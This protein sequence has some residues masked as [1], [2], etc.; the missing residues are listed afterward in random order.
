MRKII[1]AVI[2]I[3]FAL[4][5][6]GCKESKNGSAGQA[7]APDPAAAQAQAQDQVKAPDPG[8][9]QDDQGGSLPEAVKQT[10]AQAAPSGLQAVARQE[11]E[12]LAG[13]EAIYQRVNSL[14]KQFGQGSLDRVKLNHEL[15]AVK[16]QMDELNQKAGDFYKNLKLT[17]EEK[18]NPL[19]AD[20][21]RNGGRLRGVVSD[22]ISITVEGKQ[23]VNLQQKDAAGN[24]LIENVIYN[25]SKIKDYFLAQDKKYLEYQSKLAKALEK[26]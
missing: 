7:A 20:G 3:V 16:P 24:Y 26:M 5:V 13:T 6:A 12:F 9:K 15:L 22:L 4:A 8:L 17:D 10:P 2:L 11:K 23:M 18:K 1:L 21:L 19:Y 14:F 25:D